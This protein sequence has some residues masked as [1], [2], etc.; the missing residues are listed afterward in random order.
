[1]EQFSLKL[2]SCRRT[3]S[4]HF[5]RSAMAPKAKGAAAKKLA[6]VP[7]KTPGTAPP[8]A[9]IPTV[10]QPRKRAR[11]SVFVLVDEVAAVA[12]VS[13]KDAKSCLD[14]IRLVSARELRKS[15]K[16]KFPTWL[17][18]NLKKQCERPAKVKKT[19][20]AENFERENERGGGKLGESNASARCTQREGVN[21]GGA[22]VCLEKSFPA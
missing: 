10:P 13:A 7:V 3:P 6:A 17:V 21:G 19:V 8:K 16:F 22:S 14:A 5:L 2:K 12:G 4:P 20:G 11:R 15:G 18:F 1:M 9:Q